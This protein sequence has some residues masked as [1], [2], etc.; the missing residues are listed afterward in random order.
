MDCR[1][2]ENICGNWYELF[3]NERMVF[4]A[5]AYNDE[6]DSEDEVELP[7][8]WKVCDLCRGRGF[9]VNPS[10]DAGGISTE[11]FADDPGFAEDYFGGTYDVPCYRCKGRTTEPI[12]DDKA[13]SAKQLEIAEEA[14]NS[15]H[16]SVMERQSEIKYG[17]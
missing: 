8:K 4:I 12:V 7:A 1:D 14:E 9:H 13:C 15:H 11:D 5:I 3:D 6:D 2:S 17:Y 16:E 10:I